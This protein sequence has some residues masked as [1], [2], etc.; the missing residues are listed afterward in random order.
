M[1]LVVCDVAAVR[2]DITHL[3]RWVSEVLCATLPFLLLLWALLP[4]AH[5][6][7]QARAIERQE[8]SLAG[9]SLA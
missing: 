2:R 9:P 1:V 4:G 5:H 3:Q 8:D 6:S 7:M